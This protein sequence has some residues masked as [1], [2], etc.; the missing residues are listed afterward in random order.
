M[1][2]RILDA[3]AAGIP[4]ITAGARLARALRREFDRRQTAKGAEAW[5]SAPALSWTAWIDSLWA[6]CQY[7][8]ANPPVRLSAWQEWAL[9][10]GVIHGKSDSQAVMQA[11][12]MSAAAQQSWAL[13]VEWRIDLERT[14]QEGGEDAA[15]F[16]KWATK[17]LDITREQGLL[18]SARVTDA[19]RTSLSRLHLPPRVMLAG[20][21]EFTPQQKEF[22]NELRRAG[23]EIDLAKPQRPAAPTHAVKVAFPDAAQSLAAA[24]RWAR[25]ILETNPN[26]TVGI[27]VPD[28]QAR[29]SQVQQIFGGV[30]EP[31]SRLPGTKQPSNFNISAGQ[32]LADYPI[33]RSALRVLRL[34]PEGAEWREVSALVLDR[35]L[36]GSDFE[37][38]ARAV[39]DRRL[40]KLGL[41]RLT[42]DEVAR[43]ASREPVACPALRRVLNRLVK[44]WNGVPARQTPSAWARTFSDALNRAGWPGDRG[45]NSIEFQ[46][47]EAWKDVLSGFA[48]ADLTAGELELPDALSLLTRIAGAAVFQPEG[49][50]APVQILGTLEATGL[51]FDHLWVAGLDDETWPP[52]ASPDP[53]LPVRLQREAG[54]PRSSP[55]RELSFASMITGRLLASSPDVVVSHPEREGDRELAPSPLIVAVP[56]VTPDALRLWEGPA[57]DEVIRASRSVERMVDEAG[58]PVADGDGQRGGVKVFEYQAACPFRAFVELRLSAEDL[59]SPGPGLDARDRGNL[60]HWTLE[61]FW[62]EVR[63]QAALLARTD[64]PQVISESAAW[65]I[66][67]LEDRR[68]APLPERF[69]QLE[70]RRLERL[71]AEWLEIEKLREPFEVVEP[72]DEREPEVGGIRFRLKLDRIDRLRDGDVIV[73]YKTGA[74]STS[75]WDGDRPEEPQ[76]PLYSVVYTERPLAGVAFGLIKPGDMKFRGVEDHDGVMPN[77]QVVEMAAR[78]AEW[79]AVMERLAGD[80]RAGRAEPDPKDMNKSCRYCGLAG[81]CR[82]CD[83]GPIFDEEAA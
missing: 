14:G 39:L 48:G 33:V 29:R 80:F 58:P 19:V 40:R 75:A 45:L 72:E 47:V 73:D 76:L 11:A 38:S 63:S 32:S 77:A 43:E 16:V 54:V 1:H 60:V 70:R 30:L 13:A 51:Q 50:D 55:E 37:R 69:A 20:F 27:I 24:A 6:N 53:L 61:H 23:C 81:F 65:A 83:D 52:P 8:L 74:R 7:V 36:A 62:R 4:V 66:A 49:G 41:S 3:L 17:F 79:R 71:A 82:I 44:L 12:A 31:A 28:L 25:A 18:E 21:D 2:E 64:I 10:Q 9:W 15:A 67:R 46:T 42:F 35:Y 68:G 34:R 56:R 57:Y 59:E 26:E 22:F 78:V 5:Q